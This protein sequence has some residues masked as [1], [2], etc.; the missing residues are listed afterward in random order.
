MAEADGR[1]LSTAAIW[2]PPTGAPAGLNLEGLAIADLA[3]TGSSGGLRSIFMTVDDGGATSLVW[4]DAVPGVCRA[5]VNAS[6]VLTVQDV[7]DY[8]SM[9]FAA[10][11]EAD[12][13]LSGEISVQ[14]VF[15]F[16]AA[17]F[18]GCMP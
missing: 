2:G 9:Y 11:P 14:D 10:V 8:I 15:E 13:N 4:F 7:F 3:G 16:L 18:A 17:W 5:D 6:G 1:R 12:F